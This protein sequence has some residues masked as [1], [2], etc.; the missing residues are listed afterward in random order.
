M[1]YCARDVAATSQVLKALYPLFRQ[2]CPHPA[3]LGLL[4]ISISISKTVQRW[5]KKWTCIAKQEPGRA[6]QKILGTSF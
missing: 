2:R 4:F 6:R 5:V 3:T 1:R